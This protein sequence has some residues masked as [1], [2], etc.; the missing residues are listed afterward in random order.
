MGD[1]LLGWA[2]D[3]RARTLR[4]AATL[5]PDQL[6]GPMLRIVN[7]PL[8]ELG[9]VGWFQEK[10]VLR[11]AA[12]RRPLRPDGDALW[13]SIAI[14]H[15][16]RW[17]LPLPTLAGTLE[18]LAEVQDG[19]ERLLRRGDAD[20]YFV[21]LTVLHED[22]HAEAMTFSR[23]TLGWRPPDPRGA[24]QSA[25]PAAG[26]LAG[27][28]EVPGGTLRL[29]AEEDGRFVFDNEKWAHPVA[30][31]P[32]RIAR[33]P[34]TQAE[35]ARFVADGGYRRRELWSEAGWRWREAAQ[36][37]HP[38]YWEPDGAAGWRRRD[39]DRLVPLEPDRPMVHAC[40]FEA[41][42]FCRWAG[43]R[44]P[45]EAEWEA[46]AAGE[47]GS[48]GRLAPSKRRYPWGDVAPSPS[49]AHLD[50]RALAPLDVAALPAGESAFGCRQLLGNVWEWTASPF[51][52]YP[53]FVPD[54]YR[55]YSQPWF[56]DHV[57]LRGG[58][59]ATP[60]RLL[61]N[62]WRNFYTPDRRDPWAG[63]R[64]CAA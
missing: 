26:D 50:A 13:D 35:F 14:P 1:D 53:G 57:V 49:L 2:K 12:G 22:M 61:R 41:D 52:P 38:V 46:A 31:A 58:S 47:R 18:Y 21:A 7:P 40:W 28:V 10:W 25:G 23:Q 43:R 32:F 15:D 44:L 51:L 17:S 37:A 56:G 19:V 48:D 64:T 9:H 4:L 5:D 59:F 24:G 6:L 62:T 16:S 54:P 8:W 20:P 45:T 39:F 27:D 36:A 11:H 33:A 29:G 55:E 42:A 30:L 63:F 34:V 3:A 60:A